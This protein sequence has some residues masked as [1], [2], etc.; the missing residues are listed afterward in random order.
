MSFVKISDT[1][2]GLCNQIM[3]LIS[4]ILDAR[5]AGIPKILIGPFNTSITKPNYIPIDKIIDLPQTS[6]RLAMILEAAPHNHLEKKDVNLKWYTTYDRKEYIQVLKSIVWRKVFYEMSD[7]IVNN[8]IKT[9]HLNVVHFRIEDDAVKHW[10][11][12][13]KMPPEKWKQLIYARYEYLI[14]K[15]IPENSHILA[16]THHTNATLLKKLAKNYKIYCFDTEQTIKQ[17]LGIG[18]RELCALVDLLMGIR[19]T[20]TFIGC[21]NFSKHRGSTFSYFLWQLMRDAER[22]FFIDLDDLNVKEGKLLRSSKEHI[23]I[24]FHICTIGNWE[25]VVK[26]LFERIENS[27]LIY[28]IRAINVV[29]LGEY[30]EQVKAILNHPLVKIVYHSPDTQ[31]YERRCLEMM[32]EHAEKDTFKVLYIHSKGVSK[33]T[34]H[35]KYIKDWV[36]L[37][38]YYNIDNY[39]SCLNLLNEYDTCGVNLCNPDKC[40]YPHSYSDCTHYSGNFWWANSTYIKKLPEKIAPRYLDPEFWIG[41]GSDKKMVALWN[42][43]VNHYNTQYPKEI[44]F[45]KQNLYTI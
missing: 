15:Y 5:K 27:G 18:G 20:K 35:Q 44:Y 43:G 41:Q 32:R 1:W 28:A 37:M 42:S 33:N 34:I 36:E 16:L 6:L 10:S 24:Y 23:Y 9:G 14:K 31:I 8:F 4:G 29:V 19:C 40:M 26:K 25:T 17:Y 13:N 3:A 45:N 11:A 38:T 12:Q 30:L 39:Q 2:T 22:G 21:H 7:Y